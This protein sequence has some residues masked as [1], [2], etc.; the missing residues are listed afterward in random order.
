MYLLYYW[1]FFLSEITI[2][3]LRVSSMHLLIHPAIWNL[4]PSASI[5]GATHSQIVRGIGK[6]MDGFVCCEISM[7]IFY[8]GLDGGFVGGREERGGEV[9]WKKGE[10]SGLIRWLVRFWLVVDC[11]ILIRCWE[12]SDC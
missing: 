12:V 7:L 8:A 3:S 9:G 2:S 5:L 6:D 4:L 1:S 10:T 11:W